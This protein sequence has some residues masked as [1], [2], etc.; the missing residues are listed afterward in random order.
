MKSRLALLVLLGGTLC[1]YACQGR[2]AAVTT[3]PVG[4]APG[5][6]YQW[7]AD[8]LSA[9]Y[10][11]IATSI[12]VVTV[13][14]ISRSPSRIRF[15]IREDTRHSPATYAEMLYFAAPISLERLVYV[16]PGNCRDKYE[17]GQLML[18][19]VSQVADVFPRYLDAE[20]R[21]FGLSPVAK[22]YYMP[23]PEEKLTPG[24]RVILF[25]GCPPRACDDYAARGEAVHECQN[26]I[27]WKFPIRGGAV[28]LSRFGYSSAMAEADA[29]L[30]LANFYPN[31]G[32]LLPVPIR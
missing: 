6:G 30:L 31:G 13:G 10:A 27:R 16:A 21:E 23:H 20:G 7:D 14:E 12:A 1:G 24:E 11:A 26:Q 32:S 29:L 25:S 4:P 18:D 9:L 8:S 5:I 19:Y 15:D 17:R 22:H 2:E 28:D 3:A